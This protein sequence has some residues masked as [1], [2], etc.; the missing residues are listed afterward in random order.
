MGERARSR[1]RER[2]R[3]RARPTADPSRVRVGVR[4]AA[5]G[6]PRAAVS[7]RGRRREPWWSCDP[8]CR[9]RRG[10][11]RK[12]AIGDD[13]PGGHGRRLPVRPRPLV[14]ACPMA[15]RALRRRARRCAGNRLGDRARL[16]ALP[17]RRLRR[18]GARGCEPVGM[19][20]EHLDRRGLQRRPRARRRCVHGRAL[21]PLG[22]QLARPQPPRRRRR[23]A[24][25]LR[26][27]RTLTSHRGRDPV[28]AGV[29]PVLRRHQQL[30]RVLPAPRERVRFGAAAS[31][32][33]SLRLSR[34]TR[35]W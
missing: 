15:D 29:R 9:H 19:V 23:A 32:R 27:P 33:P 7:G 26:A 22:R 3:R 21:V 30:H 1:H 17:G 34:A 20:R 11:A 4:G 18:P 28:A 31:P 8:R 12:P 14:C 6:R 35:P 5:T 10:A 24:V 13:V 2:G 25:P 16:R